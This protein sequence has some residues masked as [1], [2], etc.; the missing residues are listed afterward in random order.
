MDKKPSKG[1]KPFEGCSLGINF[2]HF[3]IASKID[4]CRAILCDYPLAIII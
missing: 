3:K 4:T 1:L 2:I